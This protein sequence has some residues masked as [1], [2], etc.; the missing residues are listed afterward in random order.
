MARY[1]GPGV[2]V[3]VIENT[4]I[5]NISEDIRIPAIVGMGPSHITVTDEAVVRGAG[6]TD[7]LSN[8]SG[9]EVTQV[10]KS[11]GLSAGD[12]SAS[13]DI[14]TET[15]DY[16][17]SSAGV[18]T[19]TVSGKTEVS[20]GTVY[21]VTYTYAVPSTQTNAQLFFDDE[22][23]QDTYGAETAGVT[24]SSGKVTCGNL[25]AAG[26]IA[27]ENGS[28]AVY[29][30][31]ATTSGTYS[32][33]AYRTAIDKLENLTNVGKVI[34]VFPS[35]AVTQT[36]IDTVH[37]YLKSHCERM[38]TAESRKEREAIIGD[39][40]TDFATSGGHNTIGDTSTDPSFV[41]KANNYS[42]KRVM[43]VAPSIFDRSSPEG[44]SMELD[45]NY[46]ACA[47]AGLILSQDRSSIPVSGKSIVGGTT[48][49]ELWSENEMDY[50]GSYG[51]TVISSRSNILTVRH[52]L[53]TNTASAETVE[54]SVVQQENK[55]KRTL[56]NSLEDAFMGKGYVVDDDTL[57][58][59]QGKTESILNRLVSDNEIRAYG[60]TNNPVTGEVKVTANQDSTE[61]RRVIVSCSYA[62]L[63]PLV[64]IKVTASTYVS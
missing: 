13:T 23:I 38:S 43:Y 63:Y 42:S 2:T 61:P 48:T 64:W 21:Y 56:R 9:V 32:A 17:Y 47:L 55:V 3:E 7:T 28:P 5:I 19:W 60:T 36:E 1:T 26:R 46:M 18:I 25:T 62:P 11:P 14:L 52:A 10:S 44:V 41:K 29:L 22:D 53:T 4:R 33:G 39:A 24:I 51:V 50:L 40:Y 31:Q 35:G 45:G 16:T 34:A 59:I 58:A 49:N 27:L 6:D 20:T 15:T 37:A 12:P 57:Y 30:C 54:D 8:T